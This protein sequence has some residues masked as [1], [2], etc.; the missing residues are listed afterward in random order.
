MCSLLIGYPVRCT[1]PTCQMSTIWPSPASESGRSDSYPESAEIQRKQQLSSNMPSTMLIDGTDT[2]TST[3]PHVLALA[4]DRI[5]E[6]TSL[7]RERSARTGQQVNIAWDNSFLHQLATCLVPSATVFRVTP[8][9]DRI[10]RNSLSFDIRRSAPITQ[11]DTY[12]LEAID[13][14]R[15]CDGINLRQ[16]AVHAQTR[17]L[18]PSLSPRPL[19]VLELYREDSMGLHSITFRANLLIHPTKS[20]TPSTL[21]VIVKIARPAGA[22]VFG[23]DGSDTFDP[24]DDNA[25]DDTTVD[26]LMRER[27]EK[28][29][30]S[31]RVVDE[32]AN[33]IKVY[34][35]GMERGGGGKVGQNQDAPV[36][37]HL[38]DCNF[39]PD[40]VRDENHLIH[41]S[42]QPPVAA[43]DVRAAHCRN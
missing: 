29:V 28:R 23:I 21:P 4:G 41:C 39:P 13:I 10:S 36:L 42:T 6:R 2:L 5:Q 22:D 32:L 8:D 37:P 38:L 17:P 9:L 25:S 20:D 24:F 1:L 16:P 12:R 30:A 26:E 40:V 14:A 18:S 7:V 15:L 35:D 3:R 19:T 27:M 33:E 31:A 11:L 34:H 43:S